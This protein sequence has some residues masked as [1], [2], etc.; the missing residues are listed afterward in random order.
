MTNPPPGSSGCGGEDKPVIT[1]EPR[2][3]SA[4]GRPE[5]GE[6]LGKAQRAGAGWALKDQ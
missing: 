1:R 5:L 3:G 6:A 4:L 2:R